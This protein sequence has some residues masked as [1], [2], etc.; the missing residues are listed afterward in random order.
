MRPYFG[1]ACFVFRVLNNACRNNNLLK[2]LGVM[3][4]K[5]PK[6]FQQQKG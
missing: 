2:P 3:L 5:K 1:V 6:Y 4:K